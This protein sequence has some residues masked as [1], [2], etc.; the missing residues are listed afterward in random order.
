MINQDCPL[1]IDVDE[2]LADFLGSCLKLAANKFNIFADRQSIT[3]SNYCDALGCP[4]LDAVIDNEILTREFCYQ[5]KP[6]AGGITFLRTL[7]ERY[8]TDNVLVCTA[9]WQWDSRQTA[10]GEWASQRYAWLRDVA[11]VPQDRVIMGKRKRHVQG[12]LIDDSV[13]NCQKRPVDK[14]FCIAQP[15]NVEW[16]GNRGTYADCLKWLETQ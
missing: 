5:I 9:P 13:K 14:S 11:K 8:G 16:T 12:I 10:T 1:L 7:E 4:S 2:V 15:Y 6:I 3:K